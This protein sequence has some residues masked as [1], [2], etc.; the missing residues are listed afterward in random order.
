MLQSS[1]LTNQAP[2]GA[3]RLPSLDI[4]RGLTMMA[5][6]LV[7]NPGSWKYV[8]APLRH[9]HWNGWTLTDLIFPF[10]LWMVGFS[11]PFS[12]K[13]R[14]VETDLLPAWKQ[15]WPIFRRFLILFLAGILLAGFPF[16]LLPLQKFSLA[17]WRVP[18]VLQR[19]AVSYLVVALLYRNRRVNIPH[20]LGGALVALASYATLI[21]ALPGL[22]GHGVV[23]QPD[24]TLEQFVDR[25]I[26]G[27]HTY[28]GAPAPG[29]DPEGVISTLGGVATTL[30]GTACGKWIH[31]IT[32]RRESNRAKELVGVLAAVLLTTG[33]LLLNYLW[34]INKNL[35]SGSFVL[36]TAGLA[37]GIMLLFRWLFDALPLARYFQW[38]AMFGKNSIVAYLLSGLLARLLLFTPASYVSSEPTDHALSLK[39]ALF[40]TWILPL[41]PPPLASL[42]FAVL[43]LI[44]FIPIL[45]WMNRRKWILKI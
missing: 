15:T 8:Y 27:R 1:F 31:S 14:S 23:H 28:S 40:E 39:S 6:I 13:N 2:S 21:F 41:A 17:T 5:M 18:G 9:S 24:G 32:E 43:Y 29:F 44:C 30:L 33:G 26:F 34:P 35:W 20:L 12:R 45:W 22:P 10:F 11:I 19:I 3:R 38:A 4:F 42:L 7:N 16:G 25:F 37:L 36:F